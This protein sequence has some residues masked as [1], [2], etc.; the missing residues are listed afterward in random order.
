M[1]CFSYAGGN[2]QIYR[3][4]QNK[5][6]WFVEVCGIQRP[7]IGDRIH[8]RPFTSIPDMAKEAA[9][10]IIKE[11]KMPFYFFGHSMG[12]LIA[13]ETAKYLLKNYQVKPEVLLLSGRGSPT[14]VTGSKTSVEAIMEKNKKTFFEKNPEAAHS[15][16]EK[17]KNV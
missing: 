7:G 15:N 3:N 17:E 6:P 1:Y 16:K 13:F 10:I 14:M 5:L 12:A 8:E 4:W 9:E 2:T 11:D